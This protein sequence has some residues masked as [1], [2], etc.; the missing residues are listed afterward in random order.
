MSAPAVYRTNEPGTRYRS[1]P[2]LLAAVRA[3]QHPHVIVGAVED[4]ELRL[5]ELVALL[6][7][8]VGLHVT[9]TTEG[10]VMTSPPVV[11]ALAAVARA[12]SGLRSNRIT[13]GVAAARAA[14]VRLGRPVGPG[15]PTKVTEDQAEEIRRLKAAGTG[16]TTIAEKLALSRPTVYRVL[17]SG[18]GSTS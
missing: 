11:A 10:L 9:L 16:V 5:A 3:G 6:E 12:E 14:G 2:R 17:G 1:W 13:A 4:L 18:N 7:E 8:L 15:K